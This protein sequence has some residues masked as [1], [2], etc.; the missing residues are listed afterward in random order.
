MHGNFS[1]SVFTGLKHDGLSMYNWAGLQVTAAVVTCGG[2][3]PGL[4]DVVQ[5]I[6]SPSAPSVAATECPCASCTTNFERCLSCSKET[7]IHAIE[8]PCAM[9]VFTLIDYGV[10]EDQV[11]ST[12]YRV[13][14]NEI[15]LCSTVTACSVSFAR[16]A[17]S[18]S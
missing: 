18:T 6:V 1:A 7:L 3:C 4:N 13:M 2:L 11:E 12:D 10:P 15:P 9:Q 16:D 17:L 8:V 14:P 5:N